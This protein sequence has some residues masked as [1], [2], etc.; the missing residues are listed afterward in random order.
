MRIHGCAFLGD[1]CRVSGNLVDENGDENALRVTQVRIYLSFAVL[2]AVLVS[3]MH[4]Q[5]AVV[6]YAGT[7]VALLLRCNSGWWSTK[8]FLALQRIVFA[9]EPLDCGIDTV[10]CAGAIEL[11]QEA[12]A[13]RLRLMGT[14]LA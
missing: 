2:V 9:R 1:G 14:D 12:F 7:G 11:R 3:P 4:K 6:Q 5:V 8:S 10:D 13:I